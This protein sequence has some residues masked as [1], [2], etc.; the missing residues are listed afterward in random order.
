MSPLFHLIQAV[1]SFCDVLDYMEF[2][3]VIVLVL[4]RLELQRSP[5]I[6]QRGSVKITT[7]SHHWEWCQFSQ[8]HCCCVFTSPQVIK[9]ITRSLEEHV[10]MTANY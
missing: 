7:N 8:G 2:C 4:S 9:T 10:Q 3:M 6:P 5:V 1:I